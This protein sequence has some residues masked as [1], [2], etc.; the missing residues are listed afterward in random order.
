MFVPL[1]YLLPVHCH[2]VCYPLL[3]NLLPAARKRAS[4]T[5]SCTGLSHPSQLFLCLPFDE[6]M[7]GLFPFGTEGGYHNCRGRAL[8]AAVR[9]IRIRGKGGDQQP[10]GAE[11]VTRGVQ[12]ND[13]NAQIDTRE[14]RVNEA[15]LMKWNQKQWGWEMNRGRSGRRLLAE[16]IPQ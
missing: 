5:E 13:Q 6:G 4:T 12:S 7:P 8:R 16:P 9:P 1:L 14:R 3:P 10:L 11:E 15:A 2:T